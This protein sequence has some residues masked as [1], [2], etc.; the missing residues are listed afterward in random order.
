VVIVGE[1]I[2]TL[3]TVIRRQRLVGAEVIKYFNA[4]R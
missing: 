3:T 2:C 1:V 4:K